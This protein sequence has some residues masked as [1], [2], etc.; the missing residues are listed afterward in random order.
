MRSSLNVKLEPV[1]ACIAVVR[2]STGTLQGSHSASGVEKATSR[3]LFWAAD[4]VLLGQYER[5]LLRQVIV[6][7][8]L[9]DTGHLLTCAAE[10]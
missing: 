9:R 2:L 6:A 5:I 4:D 8:G 10:E 3:N 1:V 7:N